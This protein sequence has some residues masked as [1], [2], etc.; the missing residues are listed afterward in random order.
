MFLSSSRPLSSS[1]SLSYFSSYV[2]T[3]H[4]HSNS[5]VCLSALDCLLMAVPKLAIDLNPTATELSLALGEVLGDSRSVVH[6]LYPSIITVYMSPSSP[7]L[8]NHYHHH[9]HHRPSVR[10]R[11]NEVLVSLIAQLGT[12]GP[13]LEGLQP[14]GKH[15][16]IR[17]RQ[18]V[19]KFLCRTVD[20]VP[21]R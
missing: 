18:E 15:R 5:Q 20:L 8:R 13:V 14:A 17:M 12:P 11:A 4:S 19:A 6:H 3:H 1:F 16:N 21:G 9:H 2:H 7:Y 10:E